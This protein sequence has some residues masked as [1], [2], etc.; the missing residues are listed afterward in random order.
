[1]LTRCLQVPQ[2]FLDAVGQFTSDAGEAS[3]DPI[4]TFD[5][6]AVLAPRGRFT[7]ELYMSFLKLV[8]QVGAKV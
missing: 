4:A 1:M 5:S 7:I 8:G 2:V 3:L 6:V